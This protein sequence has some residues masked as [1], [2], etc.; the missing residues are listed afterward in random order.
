[1]ARQIALRVDP[2]LCKGCE[3]VRYSL[4][5]GDWI[6]E[7]I[8]APIDQL[9]QPFGFGAGIRTAPDLSAADGDGVCFS[10]RLSRVAQDIGAAAAG[11]AHAEADHAVVEINNLVALGSRKPTHYRVGQML[12]CHLRRI[13]VMLTASR[14]RRCNCVVQTLQQETAMWRAF[15][16]RC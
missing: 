11:A 14:V 5:Q 16:A 3:L 7:R 1:M 9:T 15:A 6:G 10:G 13:S 2:L 4:V 8:T 12:L